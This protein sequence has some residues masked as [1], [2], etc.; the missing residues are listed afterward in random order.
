MGFLDRIGNWLQTTGRK[1]FDG[2]RGGISTGFHAVQNI[3]HK[4]GQVANGIDNFLTQAK[5][6][7][8]VG[9][10]ANALQNHPYY[11]MAKEGINTANQ[12]IDKAGNIGSEVNKILDSALP[13]Q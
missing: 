1:V 6:I 8:V 11:T 10:L 9:E 7:P 13:K 2:V 3:S 12:A 4:V 5:S